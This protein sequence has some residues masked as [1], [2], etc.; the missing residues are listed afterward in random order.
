MWI[1][2]SLATMGLFAAL[3]L[4]IVPLSRAGVDPAVVLFYTFAGGCL[5]DLPY[6]MLQGTL[7][8]IAVAPLSWIACAAVLSVFGNLC[9]WKGMS[10]APNP[11]Y[12]VAI[13]ASKMLV[14]ILAS[15]WLF[16]ADISL[17]KGLGA[18]CCATGIA[19]ICLRGDSTSSS[20]R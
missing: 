12:P 8:R 19:L 17:V 15:V 11:G 4:L 10:L 13:E 3:L 6:L 7:L 5:L 18:F 2:L 20:E 14:V 1:M 16:A 9:I